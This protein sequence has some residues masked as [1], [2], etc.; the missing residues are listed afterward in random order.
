MTPLHDAAR[1]GSLA[2]AH[3]LLLAGAEVDVQDSAG[4]TPL[5]IAVD[6]LSFSVA[7]L[8]TT[9]A[10]ILTFKMPRTKRAMISYG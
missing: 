6:H 10:R 8:L 7:E 3:L 9:T 2:V 1:K 5:M 4:N